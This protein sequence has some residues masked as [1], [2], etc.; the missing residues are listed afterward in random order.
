LA[1]RFGRDERER[2]KESTQG[3]AAG[4]GD[5]PVSPSA[6]SARAASRATASA[7]SPRSSRRMFSSPPC[8]LRCTGLTSNLGTLGFQTRF[9]LS[10]SASRRTRSSKFAS[11]VSARNRPHSPVRSRAR[12]TRCRPRRAR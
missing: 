12:H 4:I 9:T 1:P 10:P 11:F 8:A 2:W 6:P 7:P 5:A 3:S